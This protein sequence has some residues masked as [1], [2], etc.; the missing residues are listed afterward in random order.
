MKKLSLLLT[1]AILLISCT[2]ETVNTVDPVPTEVTVTTK[3]FAAK[4]QKVIGGRYFFINIKTSYPV[5]SPLT[6]NAS[7]NNDYFSGNNKVSVSV[8]LPYLSKDTT[9]ETNQVADNIV[10]EPRNYK[11]DSIS[12]IS[13]FKIIF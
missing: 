8:P 1:T 3:C 11:V 9:I 12:G 10:I 6:L 4:S 5:K 2:K 7:F 13:R